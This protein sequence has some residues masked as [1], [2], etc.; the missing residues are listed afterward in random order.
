MYVPRSVA[1]FTHREAV[2]P[3]HSTAQQEAQERQ[4]Q[5]GRHR[6]ACFGGMDEG[7]G[8]GAGGTFYERLGGWLGGKST[9]W[10]MSVPVCSLATCLPACLAACF[11]L[12]RRSLIL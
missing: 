12:A 9:N 4:R 8:A 5:D 1:V 11:G 2:L 7:R 10:F 6:M 3:Q